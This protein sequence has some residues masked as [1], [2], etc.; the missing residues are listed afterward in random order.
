MNE[1]IGGKLDLAFKE[2]DIEATKTYESAT[3][4]FGSRIQVWVLPDES[5]NKLINI[6]EDDWE[7]NYGWFRLGGCNYEGDILTNFMINGEEMIGFEVANH[8]FVDEELEV[9]EYDSFSDWFYD[10]MNLSKLEN[11]AYFANSLAKYNQMSITEFFIKF[12]G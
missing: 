2:L 1:I 9:L 12:E 8:R 4:E 5:Y 7:Y 10:Y 3:N 6:T 11:M